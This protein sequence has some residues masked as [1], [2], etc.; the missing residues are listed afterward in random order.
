MNIL[1]SSLNNHRILNMF[2]SLRGLSVGDCYGQH[3]FYGNIDSDEK[4]QW[5]WTDDTAMAISIV[6]ELAE[7]SEINQD[8]LANRFAFRFKKEPFRGYGMG[9]YNL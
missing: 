6:E 7:N 2:R 1:E 3:F 5:K 4:E 9:A 8:S